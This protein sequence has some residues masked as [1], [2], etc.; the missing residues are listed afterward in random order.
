MKWSILIGSFLFLS[1]ACSPSRGLHVESLQ[2]TLRQDAASF[3]GTGAVVTDPAASLRRIPPTLALYLKP[4]GYLGRAFEWDDHDRDLALAWA[5]ELAARSVLAGARFVSPASLKGSTLLE[6]RQA[7]E[8]YG[9]DAILVLD[10]AAE[11]DRYNNYKAPLLYWTI[12]GAYVADGTHSDALCLIKATLW[13][14]KTGGRLFTETAEGRTGQVGPAALVN[15]RDEV[16]RAKKQALDRL[17]SRIAERL[18]A[19]IGA[20]R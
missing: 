17:L 14:V 3:E 16:V 9:A 7:A 6:L 11:V 15:D 19:A 4:T 5:R 2:E 18:E 13:D 1:L 12:V 8:R 10:G 20:K